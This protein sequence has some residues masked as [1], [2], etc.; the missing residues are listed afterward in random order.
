[1]GLEASPAENGGFKYTHRDTG[2]V[3]EIVPVV[4]SDDEDPLMDG[5]EELAFNPIVVGFAAQVC[6]PSLST[7]STLLRISVVQEATVACMATPWAS[8]CA[9]DA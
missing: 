2:F 6:L 3:F 5:A 8:P 4:E 9:I 7:C 1:M